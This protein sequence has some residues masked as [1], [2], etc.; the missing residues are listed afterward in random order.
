M[1]GCVV[2]PWFLIFLNGTLRGFFGAS[3]GL[4]QGDPLSSFL[5]SLVVDSLSALINH[6]VR[7]NLVEGFKLQS[8][9]LVVSH[10]WFA[11]DTIPLPN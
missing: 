8:C 7:I 2:N 9:D 5:F 10:L 4:R 1:M 11:D 6:V 3:R